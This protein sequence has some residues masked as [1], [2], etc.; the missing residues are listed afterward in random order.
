V[1][2]VKYEVLRDGAKVASLPSTTLTYN[3]TGLTAG[4]I[5]KYKVSAFDAAGNFSTSD[6][7]LITSTK[8]NAKPMTITLTWSH[9]TAREN[10]DPLGIEEIGGYEIRYKL[11]TDTQF[12]YIQI[13]GNTTTIYMAPRITM[14]TALIE[15]AAY[16]TNGLYS[17][18]VEVKPEI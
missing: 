7:E 15:I 5:Y 10:G 8:T 17:R 9:P 18:F 3:D 6:E 16:D 11:P 1:G 4:T 2:V 13:P 12:T 14:D